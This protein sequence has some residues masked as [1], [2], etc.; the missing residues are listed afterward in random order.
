MIKEYV[1]LHFNGECFSSEYIGYK[2]K[3]LFKCSNGHDSFERTWNEIKNDGYWCPN[4]GYRIKEEMCR[5]I[6]E[7][8][9]LFKFKKRRDVLQNN[10]ELDGYCEELK[11][12]FEYNG[13]QHYKE[14]RFFHQ[15]NKT[16]EK[17]KK[18]DRKVKRKCNKLGIT[19]IVIPYWKAKTKEQLEKFIIQEL[20]KKRIEIKGEVN[21]N[22]FNGGKCELEELEKLIES[23]GFKL[24]SEIYSGC[25]GYVEVFCG[26]KGHEGWFTTPDSLNQGA[27][28]KFCMNRAVCEENCL[29]NKNPK[30]AAEWH[31]IKN[32]NKTTHDFVPGSHKSAWWLCS[33]CGWEWKSLIVNRNRGVGCP[34]CARNN[35]KKD[36]VSY[37]E[38]KKII[39]SLGIKT[40][41]EFNKHKIERK[42]FRIPSSPWIIYKEK[43]INWKHFLGAKK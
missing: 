6:F 32:G 40:S 13:E 41:T 12:A 43:W 19:L 11:L 3:M 22:K 1:K 5:H 2:N 20:I 24:I 26:I 8:I 36:F 21:W 16:L 17:Q 15:D 25:K 31:P 23:K 14:V 10:L 38:C 33:I 9:N 37:E 30:L 18:R 4:C 7:Q 34:R 28:C 42:K 35:Q 27:K 39:Q 29:A